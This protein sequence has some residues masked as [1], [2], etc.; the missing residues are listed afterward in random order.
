MTRP[1]VPPSP[2]VP[3]SDS[4]VS[5]L[6]ALYREGAAGEPSA[7]LDQ[8]I[9]AAAR[10]ELRADAARQ[11]APWRKVW[12][13]P[14]SAIAVAVLGLSL[15]WQ[16]IDEQEREV[17]QEI[18]AGHDDSQAKSADEKVEARAPAQPPTPAQPS[19]NAQAATPRQRGEADAARNLP[20]RKQEQAAQPAGVVE[21][22]PFP[23][24]REA[25][26][27]KDGTAAG[28]L[29]RS[30]PEAPATPPAPPAATAPTMPA[31][32]ALK[33]NER[34]DAADARPKRD[35]RDAADAGS[36][37][38]LGKLEAKRR[39]LDAAGEAETESAAGLTAGT[40]GK[41]APRAAGK[42]VNEAAD[43]AATPAAWLQQI[44]QLRATGRKAE[45]AQSL[46]RFRARYP[47]LPVPDDL[48]DLE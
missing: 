44:R 5:E 48:L 13:R 10:T 2:N 32:D 41:A 38:P 22:R 45:A 14:A 1:G 35:G 7:M 23:A 33:Q 34:S 40:A 36:G 26:G 12:L 43:A 3:D 19:D 4:T 24:P 25:A 9:R 27:N 29:K 37:L 17:R 16:L 28:T 31:T 42:A 8:S 39:T 15:S 21:A 6:H 18:G 20:K 30:M 47:G 11:K 46:A